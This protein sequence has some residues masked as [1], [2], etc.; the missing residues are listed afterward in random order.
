MHNA[1]ATNSFVH[2][3]A[4]FQTSYLILKVICNSGIYKSVEPN[5]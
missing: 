5:G 2:N 4:V 1:M 3:G